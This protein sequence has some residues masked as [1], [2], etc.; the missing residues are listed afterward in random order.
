MVPLRNDED[1]EWAEMGTARPVVGRSDYHPQK[2]MLT[3]FWSVDGF[4]VVDKL[5]PKV[6]I[7]AAYFQKRILDPLQEI[8]KPKE[9]PHPIWLH[10]DNC[11]AHLAK[12][13][14]AHLA[15]LG[16]HRMPHPAYSPDLAPCDFYLFGTVKRQLKGYVAKT[17]DEI[18]YAFNQKLLGISREERL[19][20]M[21][22]WMK[23][24]RSVIESGGEVCF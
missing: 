8:L 23:R 19:A 12:T 11:P 24:L 1:Y 10:Y 18:A 20:T 5:P 15:Q 22:N 21:G 6:T 2:V 14:T 7:D 17:D 4:L 13:T 3:V 16:F 9:S